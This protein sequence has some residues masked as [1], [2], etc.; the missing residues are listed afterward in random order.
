VIGKF[1]NDWGYALIADVGGSSD[2]P[3]QSN[4]EN[5]FI[6]YEGFR[7]VGIDLGYIDVPFTLD[8]ATSSNDIMFIERSSA[9]VAAVNLAAG[10]NRAA[11]GVRRG[12][13]RWWGGLYLTGPTSGALHS[14]SS[15]QQLG[16][17]ARL[18]VQAL[19]GG[20]YSLHLGVNGEYV[21]TPRANG[22]SASSVARTVSFSDRPEL[23]VDPTT[24][25][26]T[27]AIPAKN[28]AVY[29]IEAAAGYHS[30]FF[31]GEYFRYSV[32]QSGLSP[33]A[34]KPTLDFD[35]GYAQASW[36]LTGESRPYVPT[37]GAYGGIVPAHPLSLSGGGWGAFELAVRYS[38]LNLNS[39]AQPGIA[40]TT[41][42]GIFG[43]RQTT[44]TIGLN[45]Y[46]VRNIR[47]MLN[48]LHADVNKIPVAV[49]GS[50]Q[51][52]SRID[53]V[54]LRTQVAF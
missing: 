45:W 51:G 26:N 24:F 53:A 23:R 1:M 47:F 29:G 41:T 54:A 17:T 13:N 32:D 12:T 22:S 33:T 39:H 35:G 43:G 52:G 3:Q 46:P 21:F 44:Y 27:G 5:A 36:T 34:P 14:G 20:N 49:G 8:E 28:A 25:L 11:A 38:Y 37:T 30:L 19:Q 7:P 40:A 42:G 31:Q 10:D 16:A 50:T 48:Y 6:S 2:G 15:Q 4:I 18:T 9:Q